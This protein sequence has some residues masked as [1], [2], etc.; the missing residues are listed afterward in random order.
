[1]AT[2]LFYNGITLKNVLTRDFSQ[3]PVRDESNTDIW[4]QQFDISVETVVSV[5]VY[6]ASVK[7]LGLDGPVGGATP[8]EILKQARKLLGEDRGTFAMYQEGQIVLQSDANLDNN[9]GPKVTALEVLQVSPRTIRILF[10]IQIAKVDCVDFPSAVIG[11]RWSCIDDIDDQFR[12]RRTWRGRLRLSNA[13]YNPQAF[14]GLVVPTLQRGWKRVAMH[15]NAPPNALELEYFISDHEM[16]GEAP[17]GPAVKM[18]ITHT[19]S[20]GQ[21]GALNA[22]SITVHLDG[23]RDSDKQLMIQRAMQIVVGKLALAS[24]FPTGQSVLMQLDLV[25]FSGESVNSVEARAL[26]KRTGTSLASIVGNM[27]T[28]SLGR[29]LQQ[30]NI[31]NYDPDAPATAGPYGTAGNSPAGL[32]GLFACYLQSP[33]FDQHGIPQTGQ[34]PSAGDYQQGSDSPSPYTY[35]EG[36]LSD[37]FPSPGYSQDHLQ[38]VYTFSQLESIIERS[39]NRIA[40]PIARSQ[41][42]QAQDTLAVV[43]L[44]PA[45]ARRRIKAS[46]E[47]VG[48]WPKIIAPKDFTDGQ[49]IK[50]FLLK[51]T[52]N[53]QA[54]EQT[55]VGQREYVVDVEYLYALNRPPEGSG[56]SVGVLPW[57][58]IPSS[59]AAFPSSAM[60]EPT[61]AKGIG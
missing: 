38:A 2:D 37:D 19:E 57:D 51:W 26:V 50:H 58:D 43:R 61:D 29:P 17:P 6:L 46:F 34:Y 21:G 55:A 32:A 27:L 49:G 54:P 10:S 36:P 11:N 9:N 14:R 41:G 59:Q 1:M 22:G 47:R 53:F 40:L 3:K 13:V 15:F 35:S 8:G 23:T 39:E 56:I 44:A 12:T 4:Y 25:D 48:D 16:L 7:M 5:D 33:C 30:L 52:P 42:G 28:Q 60:I 45:T 24:I 20:M 31:P 18:Q